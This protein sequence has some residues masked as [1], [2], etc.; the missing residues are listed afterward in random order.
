MIYLTSTPQA[1]PNP[2]EHVLLALAAV[3]LVGRLL[4]RAF[5]YMGQPPVIGEVVAGIVLGPSILGRLA[6][7]IGAII[8]PSTVAPYLGMIAQ[9]GVVLYM[10]LIGLEFDAARLRGRAFSAVVIAQAG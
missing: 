1:V 8:L 10:F 9:L 3:I 6:P 2:L 5:V 4:G 7:D